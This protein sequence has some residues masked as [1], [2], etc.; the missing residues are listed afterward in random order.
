[1]KYFVVSYGGVGTHM[2]MPMIREEDWLGHAIKRKE[3]THM[4]YPHHLR[5]PPASFKEFGYDGAL[6]LIYVFGDPINSV[7]SHFRRR[8]ANKKSWCR[9]HCMNIQ[10]DYK[11][12]NARWDLMAYL[13]QGVDL[14]RLE[15]H[16]DNWTRIEAGSIDYDYMILKYETAHRYEDRIREFLNTEVPLNF[17]KRSSDWRNEAPEIKEKLIAMY[18]GMVEKCNSF[19]E[20]RNVRMHEAG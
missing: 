7:L 12:F 16:F 3:K 5:V 2:L 11:P 13:K 6:R 1:M 10:G 14:F 20:I 9:H 15:E 18:G 19:P 8:L 4:K 17:K